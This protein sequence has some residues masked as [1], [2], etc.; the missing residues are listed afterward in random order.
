MGAGEPVEDDALG[1]VGEAEPL[2]GGEDVAPGGPCGA[3]FWEQPFEL[4]VPD[5][6]AHTDLDKAEHD[7]GEPDDADQRL[8]A[9]VVVQE[10]RADA[11]V[12]FSFLWAHSTRLWSL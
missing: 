2:E 9:V 3:A 1:R 7:E 5:S 8:D 10:D 6:A 12:C 4:V 11:S